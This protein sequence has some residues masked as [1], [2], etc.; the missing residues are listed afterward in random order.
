MNFILPFKITANKMEQINWM[1]D[2]S[3]QLMK[4]KNN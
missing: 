2:P 4:K 3:S 1:K